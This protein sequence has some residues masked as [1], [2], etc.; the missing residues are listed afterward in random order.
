MPPFKFQIPKFDDVSNGRVRGRDDVQASTE[1]LG[2][3]RL[4]EDVPEPK[5]LPFDD[6][7]DAD[8]FEEREGQEG[9]AYGLLSGDDCDSEEERSGDESEYIVTAKE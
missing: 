6:D 7:A 3:L 1:K 2:A 5:K 9:V 4:S 8:N